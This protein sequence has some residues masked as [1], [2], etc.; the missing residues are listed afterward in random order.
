MKENLNWGY[1]QL[2]LVALA[3]PISKRTSAILWNND[4]Q[5]IARV[6]K[7]QLGTKEIGVRAHVPEHTNP[8]HL[9]DLQQILNPTIQHPHELGC[10]PDPVKVLIPTCRQFV[11]S[12]QWWS[13]QHPL[14]PLEV[15][16]SHCLGQGLGVHPSAGRFPHLAWLSTDDLLLR[17][18]EI[19]QSLKRL[20]EER[21]A[22]DSELVETFSEAELR[23][24]IQ[25][26]AGLLLSQRQRASWVYDDQTGTF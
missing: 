7:R 2:S 5:S 17:R 24:A 4:G 26:G 12:E 19:Q 10:Q 11:P 16:N 23:F 1:I 22:I 25:F 18:R 13:P 20:E 6:I 3:K 21:S 14:C 9:H 8:R 15:G